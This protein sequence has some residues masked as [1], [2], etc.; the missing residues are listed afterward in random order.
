VAVCDF[1]VAKGD[2]HGIVGA[3]CETAGIPQPFLQGIDHSVRRNVSMSDL[4][5]RLLSELNRSRPRFVD[6]KLS[7]ERSQD[8]YKPFEKIRG[9]PFRLPRGVIERVVEESRPECEWLADSLGIRFT[10]TVPEQA[11]AEDALPD[12]STL[13]SL[14]LAIADLYRSR[15]RRIP[16]VIYTA[17]VQHANNVAKTTRAIRDLPEHALPFFGIRHKPDLSGT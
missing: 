3:F 12:R 16:G 11:A 7:A 17:G 13:E 1:D 10:P 5:A 15:F 2:P 6:G 9:R 4:G 14:A 8:D